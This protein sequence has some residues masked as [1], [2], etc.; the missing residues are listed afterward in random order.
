MTTISTMS[1]A[2]KPL[3]LELDDI[4]AVQGG[5]LVLSHGGDGRAVTGA[6][7]LTRRNGFISLD[8]LAVGG[9]LVDLKSLGT[10]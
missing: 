10:W 9:L 1:A 3:Q 2:G 7:V 5:T 6:G 4:L 8:P